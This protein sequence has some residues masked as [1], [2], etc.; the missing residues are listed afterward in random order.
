[1][2]T[3]YY[4]GRI[5]PG[6]GNSNHIPLDAS[7][8]LSTFV[9]LRIHSQPLKITKL[10]FREFGDIQFSY[11]EWLPRNGSTLAAQPTAKA[12]I[13]AAIKNK[14]EKDR[15]VSLHSRLY[16]VKKHFNIEE[17]WLTALSSHLS[18]SDSL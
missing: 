10:D 18:P 5:C 7:S 6:I 15:V 9:S 11:L 8:F 2:L 14:K 4:R 3:Q 13:R 17:Q 16:Y 12:T 1:M